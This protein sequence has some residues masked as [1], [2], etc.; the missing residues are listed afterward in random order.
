MMYTEEEICKR[1]KEEAS[2]RCPVK[3]TAEPGA[4]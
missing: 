1:K 2:D 3:R 4:G